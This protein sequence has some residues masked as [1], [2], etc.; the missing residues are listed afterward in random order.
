[1]GILALAFPALLRDKPP[2][3][4]L[5]RECGGESDSP[6]LSGNSVLL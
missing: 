3:V 2:S 6:S 4:G 1:M 5:N